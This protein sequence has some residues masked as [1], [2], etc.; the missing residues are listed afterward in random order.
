MA[1]AQKRMERVLIKVRKVI[2]KEEYL[3]GPSTDFALQKHVQGPLLAKGVSF[4]TPRVST[5]IIRRA[6]KGNK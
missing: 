4:L 2:L 5:D 3:K 6:P 1:T